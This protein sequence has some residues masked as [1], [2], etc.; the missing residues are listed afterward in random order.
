[1]RAFVDGLGNNWTNVPD[2]SEFFAKFA[3]Q[4]TFERLS[5]F[6]LAAR[7]LTGYLCDYTIQASSSTG[8]GQCTVAVKAY[9]FDNGFRLRGTG[10]GDNVARRCENKLAVQGGDAAAFP[11]SRIIVVRH[12]N[13]GDTKRHSSGRKAL[14]R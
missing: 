5:V 9:P 1:M 4:T 12:R 11:P 10:S 3:G 7:K 2:N 6:D 14:L 8:H 13:S